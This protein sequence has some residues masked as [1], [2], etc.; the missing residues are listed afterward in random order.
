M[1]TSC[2]SRKPRWPHGSRLR[3]RGMKQPFTH[4]EM[5]ALILYSRGELWA[6]AWTDV[7]AKPLACNQDCASSCAVAESP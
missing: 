3:L 6:H 7:V 2:P 1:P 4:A 5:T